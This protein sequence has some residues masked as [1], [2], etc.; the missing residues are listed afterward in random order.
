MKGTNTSA[1]SCG[2]VGFPGINQEVAWVKASFHVDSGSTT[3]T[4]K[5]NGSVDV[6]SKVV[7]E[8]QNVVIEGRISPIQATDILVGLYPVAASISNVRIEYA[9]AAQAP[10][11]DGLGGIFEWIKANP[12]IAGAVAVGVYL[13]V[14][15]K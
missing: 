10:A 4:V 1:P 11:G 6:G 3:V 9:D 8:G 14:K 15:G 13:L 12:L 7:S 5:V 2:G